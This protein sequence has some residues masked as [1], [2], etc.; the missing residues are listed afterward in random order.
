MR[1]DKNTDTGRFC[2]TQIMFKANILKIIAFL[3]NSEPE[4]LVSH[5]KVGGYTQP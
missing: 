5:R 2:K 3:L 1:P 4:L